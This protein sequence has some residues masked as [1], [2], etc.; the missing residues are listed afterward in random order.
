MN[1]INWLFSLGPGE[2]EVGYNLER[3]MLLFAWGNELFGGVETSFLSVGSFAVPG[4]ES[5]HCLC[6]V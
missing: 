4:V 2:I 6:T 3:R 1:M 5:I